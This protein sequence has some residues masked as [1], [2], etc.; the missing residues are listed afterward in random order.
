M[1]LKIRTRA[2]VRNGYGENRFGNLDG[3]SRAYIDARL[4]K[5]TPGLINNRFAIA[6]SDSPIRAGF[7]ARPT[8]IAHFLIDNH[9]HLTTLPFHFCPLNT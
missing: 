9:C 1:R 7:K 6:H 2:G 8:A 3:T 4:T 5:R